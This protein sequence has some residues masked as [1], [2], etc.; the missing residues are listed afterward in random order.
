[1]NL[2]MRLAS[3]VHRQHHH[4]KLSLAINLGFSMSQHL[5][6]LLQTPPVAAEFFTHPSFSYTRES[7]VV[8]RSPKQRD[9]IPLKILA[10]NCHSIV[11]K[12]PLLENMFKS[13][14][15]D[16]VLGTESWL[17]H[18]QLSLEIFPKGFKVYRKDRTNKVG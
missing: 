1:M 18:D 8:Q 9:D 16:I 10:V 13:K 17:K 5:A 3:P 14:Q 6:V 4:L 7:V 2:T 12:K 15:A 11:E